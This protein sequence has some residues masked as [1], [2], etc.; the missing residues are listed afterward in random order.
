MAI[1]E[2]VLE[3]HYHKPML[4]LIRSTYGLGSTGHF[5]F[6]KYSP[7]KEVFL[8]FDQAYAMTQYSDKQFFDLLKNSALNSG[9][10]L[11]SKFLAYFLQY[12]VVSELNKRQAK[13]PASVTNKPHYRATLDTTKNDRTGF[14][15]H[16]LLYN[17]S[18][19]EGAMVYYACPMIFDKAEL[20]EPD[21]CLDALQL[22]DM[23]SC[24]GSFGDNSRHYIYFDQKTA[25]PVWCSEPVEGSSITAKSFAGG[26]ANKFRQIEFGQDGEKIQSLLAAIKEKS[27]EP[28]SKSSMAQNGLALVSDSLTVIQ[29]VQAPPREN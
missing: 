18:S 29:L 23:A 24:P 17:L 16:E 3:M 1:T 21:P 2:T 15:Q 20:Y 12:K 4:D 19:N 8:G 25:Q 10:R 13:T 14:S 27:V 22:V 11:P 6:Y 28:N 7:Q 9:Y 5:N 26:I